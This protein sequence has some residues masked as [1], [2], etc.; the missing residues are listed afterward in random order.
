MLLRYTGPQPVT[1]TSLGVEVEP[2]GTFDIPDEDAGSFLARAD[3]EAVPADEPPPDKAPRGKRAA[4]TASPE[5]T[6]P[7]GDGATPAGPV[8]DPTSTP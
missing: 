8:P 3:I 7:A 1:F 2:G 6:S 4:K 5:T